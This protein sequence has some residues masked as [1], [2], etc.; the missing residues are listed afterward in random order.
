MIAYEKEWRLEFLEELGIYCG[1]PISQ[2]EPISIGKSQKP[3]KKSKI[4]RS[5]SSVENHEC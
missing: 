3:C 1:D 5:V 2:F 4:C